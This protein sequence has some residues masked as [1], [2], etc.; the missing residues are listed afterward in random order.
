MYGAVVPKSIHGSGEAERGTRGAPRC[1]YTTGLL[2]VYTFPKTSGRTRVEE[3]WRL[4]GGIRTPR[5]FFQG[6]LA[7]QFPMLPRQPER[8]QKKS[9]ERGR[10]EGGLGRHSSSCSFRMRPHLCSIF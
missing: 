9:E 4:V 8:M 10:A 5:I 1:V 3:G 7:T 2:R 6:S